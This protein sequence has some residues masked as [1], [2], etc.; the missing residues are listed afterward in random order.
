MYYLH[1]D[2]M[3]WMQGMYA[4]TIVLIVVT[5][6]SDIGVELLSPDKATFV[7]IPH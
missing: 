3:E 6:N 2:T 7:C 4:G 1:A 5:D